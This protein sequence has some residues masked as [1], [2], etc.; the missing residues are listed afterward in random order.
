MLQAF[1][2]I[3]QTPYARDDP[4]LELHDRICSHNQP[5]FLCPTTFL[6]WPGKKVDKR[7]VTFP[8]FGIL[9]AEL[10]LQIWKHALPTPRIVPVEI[11]ILANSRGYWFTEIKPP[12]KGICPLLEVC[13]ESRTTYLE[14]YTSVHVSTMPRSS[15]GWK[16]SFPAVYIDRI[17]DS[18]LFQPVE[19]N[20]TA[21][22]P[23]FFELFDCQKTAIDDTIIHFFEPSSWNM[24]RQKFSSMKSLQVLLNSG[25]VPLDNEQTVEVEVSADFHYRTRQYVDKSG[26]PCPDHKLQSF[27]YGRNTQ[28]FQ[29]EA[30]QIRQAAKGDTKEEIRKWE[31]ISIT[32][33]IITYKYEIWTANKL[34]LKAKHS[35]CEEPTRWT[36]KPRERL[37]ATFYD[38]TRKVVILG[39]EVLDYGLVDLFSESQDTPSAADG[40]RE[41]V[42]LHTCHCN[43]D[44]IMFALKADQAKPYWWGQGYGH[45]FY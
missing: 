14:S 33:A 45:Q 3:V 24:L 21:F 25:Y 16:P 4:K 41:M 27:D 29:W 18:I 43:K 23:S 35:D 34:L 20:F 15:P 38:T 5:L 11:Q 8:K 7:P 2:D 30:E 26:M 22:P 9:P 19:Q 32:C 42:D 17:H 28:Y 39:D 44:D 37:H 13:S 12:W 36:L 31:S 40:A 1:W 6:Q 10:R